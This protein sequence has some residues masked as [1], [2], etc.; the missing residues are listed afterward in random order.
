MVFE[1]VFDD[2]ILKQLKQAAKNKHIEAI[3][4][5]MMDKIE[6][7]GP[8][9]GQLLDSH[10]FLYEMKS[11]SP[12]IRLYFKHKKETNEMYILAYEMKTNEKKQQRI[13]NRLR[14]KLWRS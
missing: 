9:A 12:P 6:E 8:A 10:L 1:L 14:L 13:I 7:E 5:T 3:L 2:V 4:T 11:K